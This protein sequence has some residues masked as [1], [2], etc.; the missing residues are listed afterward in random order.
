MFYSKITWAWNI[1]RRAVVFK[2]F[3]I[4]RHFDFNRWT[5]DST[6]SRS[7]YDIPVTCF[8]K[9]SE[10]KMDSTGSVHFNRLRPTPA[11]HHWRVT[12]VHRTYRILEFQIMWV[13][14]TI[15]HMAK[16]IVSEGK[17]SWNR[18]PYRYLNCRYA[19]VKRKI[20]YFHH[21]KN[22]GVTESGTTEF[23]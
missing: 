7:V 8:F 6:L 13:R 19:Y 16:K 1:E 18:N 3:K 12:V 4:F 5:W 17:K 20:L 11:P 15:S 9:K 22:S 14:I 2:E 23:V 10:T 21:E